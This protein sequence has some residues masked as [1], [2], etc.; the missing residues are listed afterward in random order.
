MLDDTRYNPKWKG[1]PKKY[2][3][4][5]IKIL[6]DHRGFGIKPTEV[7]MEHLRTL[8]TQVS[9]DNAI[10]TIINNRWDK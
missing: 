8:T 9:I 2:L 3:D 4:A 10:W 7:E 1:D 5:K 6:E